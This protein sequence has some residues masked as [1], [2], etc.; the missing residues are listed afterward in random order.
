MISL[1]RIYLSIFVRCV[2]RIVECQINYYAESLTE[3]RWIQ[4]ITCRTKH[5][6]VSWSFVGKNIREARISMDKERSEKETKKKWEWTL[7]LVASLRHENAFVRVSVGVMQNE[8]ATF[9]QRKLYINREK[10]K[11]VRNQRPLWHSLL[12][13]RTDGHANNR[14][15]CRAFFA[16]DASKKTSFCIFK[17]NKITLLSTFLTKHIPSYSWVKA[18]PRINVPKVVLTGLYN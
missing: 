17:D 14:V 15:F 7:Y 5:H 3:E 2:P 12:A 9:Y 16:E 18:I 8:R 4:W 11:N 10:L 13:I 1:P 6:N